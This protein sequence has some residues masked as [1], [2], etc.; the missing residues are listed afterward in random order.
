M[1]DGSNLL[2]K[3]TCENF[4]THEISELVGTY[5][6][7][8]I[9]VSSVVAFPPSWVEYLDGLTVVPLIMDHRTPV[10]VE[11][12][13][14]T[15]ATLG[16]DRLAAAVG[17]TVVFPRTSTLVIDAGTAITIDFVDSM[18]RFLGGNISPGLAV[19]FKSLNQNTSKLPLLQLADEFAFFGHDTESAIVAGVQQGAIYELDSYI[20]EFG[21]R[22]PDLKVLF[23]GGD[24]FFFE[25]NLK[26]SIFVEPFL[27]PKGLNR[28]LDYN[29]IKD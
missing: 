25:K 8:G 7:K 10:P 27:V 16:L 13:Y 21:A 9:I 12:R 2:H 26:N 24:A 18:G 1:F 29:A 20:G 6:V 14:K 19:R 23:T 4:S 17:A 3:G 11:N 28:I 5:P 15:P 22:C